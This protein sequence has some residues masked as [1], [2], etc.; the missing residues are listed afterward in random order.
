MAGTDECEGH[1]A[2]EACDWQ[3]V[4][5]HV[6]EAVVEGDQDRAGRS[7]PTLLEQVRRFLRM[8]DVE[9][10]AQVRQVTIELI[11]VDHPEADVVPAFL[12]RRDPVVHENPRPSARHQ[13]P[14]EPGTNR[15]TTR[16]DVEIEPW[17]MRRRRAGM[18]RWS[19]F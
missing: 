14:R 19:A 18:A 1:D 16:D 4:I 5:E 10:A 12:S 3:S 11:R 9:T 7:G 6:L 15:A 17:V 8:E 13:S 2:V